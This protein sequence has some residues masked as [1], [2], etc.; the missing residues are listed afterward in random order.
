MLSFNDVAIRRGDKLLLEKATFAIFDGDKVGV[1]GANGVGK[2]SLF[3]VLTGELDVDAGTV[4][5]PAR[6]AI[7]HLAQEVPVTEQAAIDYVMDGDTELRALERELDVAH[8]GERIAALHARMDAIDGYA[9]RAR[10]GKLMNGLGFTPADEYRPVRTF[11]GGWRMRLNLARTLMCRSD[12]LLLDEPTNHL[13]L[14][15]LLWLEQW[16]KAFSGTLLLISHDR[17]FL[18]AVSERTL[19]LERGP[20]SMYPG[21]YSAFEAQRAERLAGQQAAF[22]KQQRRIAH[23][24]SFVERFR[25]KATKAKQA[26]SRLKALSRMERLAPAHVDSAL[27]F[28]FRDAKALPRP[29]LRLEDASAGYAG[30]PVLEGIGI[31]I[32]PGDR[33]GLLGKNGSGKSTFIRLLA[34]EI[35]PLSGRREASRTLATGYFAQHHLEQL[36]LTASPL[37]HLRRLDG[38]VDEQQGRD[39]LGAFG[40]HGDKALGPVAGLSGGEK[41]RLVLAMLI[42]LRPNLLLLDEPTNHLDLDMRHAL[43]IALQSFAGAIVLVSHDRHLIDAVSDD[44]WLARAGRVER[45]P[46][47]L[48]AYVRSL[49]DRRDSEDAGERR[50]PAKPVPGYRGKQR[51]Q[52]EARSR[53]RTKPLRDAVRVLEEEILSLNRQHAELMHKLADN[54]LYHQDADKA[55]LENLMIRQSELERAL[56]RAEASWLEATVALERGE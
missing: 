19:S 26:Q 52:E 56:E 39:Y 13:D 7:S 32:S 33:I 20:A 2:S 37:V 21:N 25:Y 30:Q 38:D 23:M 49:K 40:F 41:A 12:L 55:Y 29:L 9:A 22:E 24:R 8:E 3:A 16:L 54:S 48:A 31:T 10:A 14:D 47:D 43:T 11:S 35:E 36:D 1:I 46:D 42:H 15:A 53:D 18:D 6:L 51:R 4:E 44:L 17:V 28:S 50:G 45:Y 27:E 34:G 5:I